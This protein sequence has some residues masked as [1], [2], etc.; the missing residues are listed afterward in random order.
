MNGKIIDLRSDTVTRPTPEMRRAMYKAEVGDDVLHEDPTM[1]EL[2]RYA[3]ELIGKEAT[4]FVPSGTFGNELA[5]FTHCSRGD[6]V[7]LSEGGHIVQHEAGAAAILAGVQL[8]T[9]YEEK[10]YPVWPDFDPRIRKEEDIHCP[11]TGL[12]VLENALSSGEVMNLEEMA[13]IHR[14]AD[15]YCI[16][17]HLDGARI[18]NAAFFLQT[19]AREIAGFADSVMFCLSKGLCA[20]V[21]SL[22]AGQGDFIKRARKGRKIMGGGMRQAG[23]LAAAGLVALRK[24]CR[25]LGDDHQKAKLLADALSSRG[26]FE[27]KPEKV[28]INI[29]HVRFKDKEY[30]GLEGKFVESL[31]AHGILIYPPRNGW[32]RFVTHHD[33]SF[34]DINHVVRQLDSVIQPLN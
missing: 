7:L 34:E 18:Y 8:R 19:E 11:S 3:A 31:K 28:K 33:I 29:L 14:Q 13:E 15:S 21:G 20:P 6:E 23:I 2:E 9:I 32:V 22:L 12:I 5:L 30:A 27:L 24:M 4:L 1:N 25:R 17:V 10:S 26:L 16:P